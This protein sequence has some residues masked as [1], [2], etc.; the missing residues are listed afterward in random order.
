M[1][2]AAKRFSKPA[3][4]GSVAKMETLDH[5]DVGGDELGMDWG[6]CDDDNWGDGEA[7]EGVGDG[8]GD[9]VKPGP[10]VDMAWDDW[11]DDFDGGETEGTVAKEENREP[12]MAE[13]EKTVV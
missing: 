4:V 2:A 8:D 11:G 3:D 13:E 10:G 12:M 5:E 1:S 7:M 9:G 6:G